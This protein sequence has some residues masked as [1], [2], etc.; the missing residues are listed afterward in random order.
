KARDGF[1]PVV[2]PGCPRFR[3]IGVLPRSARDVAWRDRMGD[4]MYHASDAKDERSAPVSLVFR[5]VASPSPPTER[6]E[7]I[8][9]EIVSHP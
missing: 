9:R 1:A 7:Y 2:P 3:R 8:D 4:V 5:T 6:G